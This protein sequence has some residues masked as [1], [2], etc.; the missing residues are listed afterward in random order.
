M[1]EKYKHI[2]HSIT[3]RMRI[4]TPIG[5]VTITKYDDEPEEFQGDKEAIEWVK[6]QSK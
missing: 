4:L 6:C 3:I 2:A 1:I 5:A